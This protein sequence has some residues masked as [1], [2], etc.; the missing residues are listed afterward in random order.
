MSGSNKD[1][2]ELKEFNSFI[3]NPCIRDQCRQDCV[4]HRV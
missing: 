3:N 2:N 1:K 4:F